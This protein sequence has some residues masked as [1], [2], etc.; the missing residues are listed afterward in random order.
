MSILNSFFL[1]IKQPRYRMFYRDGDW[2]FKTW[3]IIK[4]WSF[5]IL[6]VFLSEI[7]IAPIVSFSGFDANQN[8]LID[9]FNDQSIYVVIFFTMIFAPLF[10]ELIFRLPLRCGHWNLGFFFSVFLFFLLLEAGNYFDF[11]FTIWFFEI[12]F[13]LKNLALILLVV[14][15]GFLFSKIIKNKLPLE[16]VENLYLKNFKYIFYF[17]TLAFG[18]VH[19]MNFYNYGR[20]WYLILFLVFPQMLIS[21]SLGFV[22]IIFGFQWSVFMHFLHNTVL[23]LP[24]IILSYVSDDFFSLINNS[25]EF[26][27][28]KISQSDKSLIFFMSY[29]IIIVL[30][31]FLVA[32]YSVLMEYFQYKK[33]N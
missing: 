31:V 8:Y 17:F 16:K 7:F 6:L 32:I 9:F 33:N 5:I 22:R 1:F 14:F 19:I 13:Y 18:I 25:R 23:T 29:Y 30:L 11:D 27:P 3:S 26:D 12:N 4:L 15:F 21:F 28:E 20:Y 24:I 10:E 2:R